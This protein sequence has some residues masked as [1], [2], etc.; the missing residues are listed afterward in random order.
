MRPRLLVEAY[1]RYDDAELGAVGKRRQ[2]GEPDAAA[3]QWF[4]PSDHLLI[5]QLRHLGCAALRSGLLHLTYPAGN[6][7]GYFKY[8]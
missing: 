2:L 7:G 6:G 5:A 4:T 8:L 3:A 1:L